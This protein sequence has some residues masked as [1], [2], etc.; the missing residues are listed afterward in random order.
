MAKTKRAKRTANQKE[1]MKQRRRLQGI[2]NRGKRQGYVFEEGI[3]PDL[4]NRVTNKKLQEI[5]NIKADDLYNRAHYID[6]YTGEVKSGT[7]RRKEVREIGRLKAKRTKS[8]QATN[9]RIDLIELVRAR[10]EELERKVYPIIPIDEIR[11]TLLSIFDD[12]INFYSDSPEFLVN[13]LI[14]N[15][16][17]I[18]ELLSVINYESDLNMVK[19]SFAQLGNLLNVNALSQDQAESLSQIGDYYN[20]ED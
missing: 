17:E 2:V 19:V 12:T 1:Y 13:Y 16:V 15:E 8:K 7:E 18:S 4:P 20:Y 3:I 6:K 10:I 5:R 11:H 14:K 9:I